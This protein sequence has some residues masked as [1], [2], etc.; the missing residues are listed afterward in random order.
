[1]WIVLRL[2]ELVVKGDGIAILDAGLSFG[3]GTLQNF[4]INS[5]TSANGFIRCL[6]KRRELN[7]PA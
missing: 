2:N 1:L 7:P 3:G 6:Y 4:G 5:N